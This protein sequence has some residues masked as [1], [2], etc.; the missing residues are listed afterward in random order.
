MSITL[1]PL[2]Q[3]TLVITGASSGI[4]LV[5][6][7]LAAEQGANVVL[8]SRNADALA[9]L[10]RE[11]NAKGRGQAAHV[12]ADVG[13][14]D[15]VKRIVQK[16]VDRFGGFDTWVNNAGASVYGRLEQVSTDDHRR[17][18]ETN[19]WGVVFGSLAAVGHLK[20]RMGD[21][22]PGAGGAL[23]NV[24]STLSD[25]AIPLQGMYCASKHAV[26]GF[27][28]ALRMEVEEAGYPI[29]IT[30]IKPSAI[31]TPYVEH[32]KNYL[33]DEPSNPPPVYAPDTVAQAILFAAE[34]P[35]RDIFVGV[36][37]KMMSSMG[38]IAPRLTDLFM[39]R[40][41]FRQQHSGRPPRRIPN[42]LHEPGR[43]LM[44]RGAYDG[45]VMESSL[46]TRATQHPLMT[47]L[48][49]GAAG[50]AVAALVAA[51]RVRERW[52]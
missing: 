44:E 48:I 3:Q 43:G 42:G 51:P 36:G 34:H 25:R 12:V 9:E 16:A 37:G 23:I 18:M 1:K 52:G 8:A 33:N 7:R 22:S 5:T 19:F 31:N 27:T 46:Y 24:G 4:G 11:I 6:A 2:Y 38:K 21:E 49:L 32:A 29:S 41:M 35:Q 45:H 10:E 40:T 13:K 39:E 26:K 30:L 50:A 14:E 28:D 47:G 17:L 20:S 15:E